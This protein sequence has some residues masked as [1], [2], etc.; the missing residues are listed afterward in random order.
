MVAIP[1]QVLA[2]IQVEIS[3]PVQVGEGGRGRPA[4][5]SAQAGGLGP[6]F[7]RPVAPV[8][9]QGV[10][11]EAG[12]EEVG[13]AVVIIV[14]DRHSVAVAT[15]HRGDLRG[16]ADILEAAVAAVAEEAIAGRSPAASRQERSALD[17]VHVEPAV[18]VVIEQPDPTRHRLGELAIRARIVVE[19]EAETGTL[20]VVGEGRAD[21]RGALDGEARCPGRE[22]RQERGRP[23]GRP[24][25]HPGGLEAGHG[26]VG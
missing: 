12:D 1:A 11:A 2:D 25:S 24:R 26:P 9:I 18:A 21:R 6:V 13:P 4:A 20:G 19:D 23:R 7:K 14:A 15:R 3:V 16:L 10:G 22:P 8:A 5:V 17:A